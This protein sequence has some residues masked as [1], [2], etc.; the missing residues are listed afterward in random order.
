VYYA[1]FVFHDFLPAPLYQLVLSF[2]NV[3]TELCRHTFA[4]EDLTKLRLNCVEFL[5]E[6]EGLLPYQ[7]MTQK[8]HV[9]LHLPDHIVDSG[10][11][12]H[13]SSF[14]LER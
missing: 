13:F 11:P 10:P 8:M 1:P 5:L 2:S 3:L 4:W 12:N 9:L 14:A 7:F 6:C